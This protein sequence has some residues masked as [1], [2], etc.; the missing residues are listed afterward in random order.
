[1][2]VTHTPP[3]TYILRD[4]HDVAVPA[5]ISW[6]PQTLGWKLVALFI[7]LAA[8][9]GGYRYARFWW[10]NRYRQEALGAIARLE[11]S[12]PQFAT[13]LFH[14]IKVVLVYLDSGNSPLFGVP[15]TDKLNAICVDTPFDPSLAERWMNHLVN[16][17]A[18]LSDHDKQALIAQSKQWLSRHQERAR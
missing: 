6:W 4:L 16:P 1:M 3:S 10:R 11:L 12:D 18:P 14:I 2:S 5:S 7:L 17:A 9:Y 13:Q 8:L 15:F